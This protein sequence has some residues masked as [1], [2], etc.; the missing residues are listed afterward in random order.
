[1]PRNGKPWGPDNPPP[2]GG[3]PKGT[4]NKVTVRVRDEIVA[5]YDRIGGGEAF[6][7]WAQTHRAD[8]YRMFATLAP[9]PVEI[10]VEDGFADLSKRI[11]AVDPVMAE[12]LAEM[13]EG[14]RAE[15]GA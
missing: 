7:A 1:M 13:F 14:W 12:R 2:K 6:A 10:T 9:R 3:R 5:V 15:R 4:P 11:A 8:F